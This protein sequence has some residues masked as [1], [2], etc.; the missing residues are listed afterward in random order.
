MISLIAALAALFPQAPATPVNMAPLSDAQLNYDFHCK[1][2]HEP[3]QPGVPDIAVL[4][5]LRPAA[6][7]RSLER[8]NMKAMGATLTPDERRALVAYI[9]SR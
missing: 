9:T 3:A 5:T 1:S 7:L 8:G 6:I 2:C 4:K